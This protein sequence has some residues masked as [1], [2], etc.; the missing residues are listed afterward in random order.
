MAIA[1]KEQGFNSTESKSLAFFKGL[2]LFIH[3]P[4]EEVARFSDAAQ[5]KNYKK[6]QILYSESEPAAFF[7]IICSGWIKLFHTTAE[8]EEMILAML[9]RDSVTGVK[10]LF[11]QERFTM[12][13]QVVEDAEIFSIPL[14]LL[15]ERLR[16]NNQLALN[17]ISYMVQQQRRYEL[18]QEQYFLYSAPQRIGCF[19]LGLCPALEQKDGVILKLPYDKVL[20][21]SALGM[22]APTFSR[23]LNILRE[24]TGIHITGTSVT[25]DSM[26]RLLTFVDGCYSHPNLYK[27]L[28]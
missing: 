13:A 4:D 25:I 26:Q 9:T 21:A 14:A 6:G 15:K 11:E 23:A 16:T 2:T 5:I 17:M 22:K 3:I 10:P 20:I 18:H 8:G 7:H 12:S 1:L 27:N 19:L 24:E 28:S